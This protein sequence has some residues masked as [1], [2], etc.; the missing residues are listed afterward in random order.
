MVGQF[1]RLLGCFLFDLDEKLVA[2]IRQDVG[3]PYILRTLARF[4]GKS[5]W[6]D[7][8]QGTSSTFIGDNLLCEVF[9]L[10]MPNRLFNLPPQFRKRFPV[11]TALALTRPLVKLIPYIIRSLISAVIDGF[12]LRLSFRFFRGGHDY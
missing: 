12:D 9:S 4:V 6:Y 2:L 1:C 7:F 5:P 3:I 8:P 11:F 10:C